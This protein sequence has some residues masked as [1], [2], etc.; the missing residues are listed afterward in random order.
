VEKAK[1]DG[2]N[3]EEKKRRKKTG[4]CTRSARRLVIEVGAGKSWLGEEKRGTTAR[5]KGKEE[6]GD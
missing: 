4:E 2:T 3:V 6:E 5:T 1:N